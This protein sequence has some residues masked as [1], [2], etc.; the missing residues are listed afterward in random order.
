MYRQ[1]QKGFI[2]NIGIFIFFL[3]ITSSCGQKKDSKKDTTDKSQNK[4]ENKVIQP[5]KKSKNTVQKGDLV[6]VHYIGRFKNGKIFDQSK[7]EKPLSFK[8]GVGE[9]VP[10]FDNAVLSMKLG[11]K[12]TVDIPMKDAY[13]KRDEKLEQKLPVSMFPKG[14]KFEIGKTIPLQDTDTKQLRPVIIKKFDDKMV[15][16][17][18]NHPMAGKDL[19]FEIQLVAIE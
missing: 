19:Q 18:L 17:D 3:L 16:V 10:G 1:L 11:E 4:T 8:A 2:L 7:K 14:F 5:N 6:T 12:K 9:V 15:T 13:G